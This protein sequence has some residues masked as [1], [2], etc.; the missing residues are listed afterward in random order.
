MPTI[1]NK[2]TIDD[3]TLLDLSQ[4]TVSDASHIRQGYVGHLN[5]G[6]QVTGTYSGG[7]IIKM[8][9]L[10][11]DAELL[12]SW[13]YNKLIVDDEEVTIP[14]YSTST[15]NV[16][17]SSSDSASV[18]RETYDYAVTYRAMARPI[19]SNTEPAKAR[20]EYFVASG[21]YEILSYPSKIYVP[22]GPVVNA[23]NRIISQ[24]EAR[25]LYWNSATTMAN[26]YLT[27][28]YGAYTMIT[29]PTI[30]GTPSEGTITVNFPYLAMRGSTTYLDS[31]NWGLIT[32]I[33][34]QYVVELW[35]IS[36]N[37]Q[38]QGFSVGSMMFHTLDCAINGDPLT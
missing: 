27:T 24:D 14:D 34:F 26:G 1:Y 35:R 37:N 32:D 16:I 19:Y 3:T 25:M 4:D 36:K 2:V 11:S 15:R 31:T 18:D 13:T 9:V 22:N 6:S 33:R 20:E 7:G 10:R 5:D 21:I 23:S 8:G 12:D 28:R 17:S 30:S 29:A 38:V